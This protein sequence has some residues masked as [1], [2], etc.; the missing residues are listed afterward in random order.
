VDQAGVQIS[1]QSA[2]TDVLQR[3]YNDF[4]GYVSKGISSNTELQTRQQAWMQA[5]NALEALRNQKLKLEAELTDV[6]DQLR[7]NDPRTDA[8]INRMRGQI[9][10]I[11]Q[12]T[13]NSEASRSVEVRAP[14]DGSVTAIVAHAGQTVSTNAPLLKIVPDSELRAELLAPSSA[15]G[16]IAAGERVLLRYNAFPYQKFG[17]YWGTV[18]GVSRAALSDEE[19]KSLPVQAQKAAYYRITVRPDSAYVNV[20]GREQPLRASMQVDA[21]VLLDR[22]PLYQWILEPLYGVGRSLASE[23]R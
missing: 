23:R 17:Q 1:V 2:F 14:G 21:F 22:R 19:V 5:K 20:Y 18:T 7:T 6:E 15:V 4:S 9:L 3:Q 8:E 11:D 16:F 12:K 10:D 13:A